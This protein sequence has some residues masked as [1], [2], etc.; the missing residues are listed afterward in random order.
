MAPTIGTERKEKP[1]FSRKRWTV[2]AIN[3]L[4][5]SRGTTYAVR[6]YLMKPG[7]TKWVDVDA[8]LNNSQISEYAEAK[9]WK[10]DQDAL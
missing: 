2:I 7:K 5:N 3:N 9:G 1:L 4:V 10:V 6:F 8:P